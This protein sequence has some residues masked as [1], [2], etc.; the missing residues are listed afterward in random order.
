VLADSGEPP[1]GG[2]L[3][4]LLFPL[5]V[6][7]GVPSGNIFRS[8][9]CF[10]GFQVKF[11]PGAEIKKKENRRVD[12]ILRKLNGQALT[13]TFFGGVSLS[14]PAA[15]VLD[16]IFRVMIDRIPCHKKT[17]FVTA[18]IALRQTLNCFPVFNISSS[19]L[20]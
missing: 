15:G 14:I 3:T 13:A 19:P 7:G 16:M 10:I 17:F 2:V 20:N 18:T 8:T 6:E 12:N 4:V 9:S 1:I 11:T 5:S